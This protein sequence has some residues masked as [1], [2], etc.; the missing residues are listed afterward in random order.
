MQDG[1]NL[2]QQYSVSNYPTALNP[3]TDGLRNI[4]GRNNGDGTV[5]IWAVTSTVSA[6]GDQGADPNQLLA[7]TDVL[8]NTDPSLASYEPFSTI[9]PPAYG[10][11]LRGVSFT[12]G[13]VEHQGHR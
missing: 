2:G 13:T 1:L 12:P 5:T 6:S 7:I 3:A 10:I 9:V 11:V 8:D 4:T